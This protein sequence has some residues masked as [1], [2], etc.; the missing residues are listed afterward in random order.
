MHRHFQVQV[1]QE[2]KQTTFRWFGERE[3]AMVGYL[4]EW[5]RERERE[6]EREKRRQRKRGRKKRE[7][8]VD[9]V[10]EQKQRL[11]EKS[12]GR[13]KQREKG[14][15][16]RGESDKEGRERKR[17]REKNG[18]RNEDGE[19]K[20]E[21]EKVT[22]KREAKEKETEWDELMRGWKGESRTRKQ[23]NEEYRHFTNECLRKK[24]IITCRRAEICVCQCER[25]YVTAFGVCR[26]S[27]VSESVLKKVWL[28]P[29][30]ERND[31]KTIIPMKKNDW[32][33]I[34]Q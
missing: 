20:R 25:G 29:I 4:S 8:G 12:R 21:G 11:K 14:R 19:T 2:S 22:V 1:L 16:G 17:E 9:N 33:W 31:R 3:L 26:S 24:N 30:N 13:K 5:E 15:K 7:R 32:N 34:K 27:L 6:R 10:Q 23:A 28:M 18:E